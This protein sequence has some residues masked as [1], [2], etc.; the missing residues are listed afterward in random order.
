M[1]DVLVERFSLGMHHESRS[2]P[3]YVLTGSARISSL[4]SGIGPARRECTASTE[5]IT[6]APPAPPAAC[7]SELGSG[8]FR[9]G[10]TTMSQLARA[11]SHALNSTVVD[12]TQSPGTFAVDLAWTAG[13]RS[14]VVRTIAAAGFNLKATTEPVDVLVIDRASLPAESGKRALRSHS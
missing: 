3:T 6:T 8:Y 12:H 14:S 1:R 11:L 9:S 4:A 10:A 7:G 5:R 13:D 2:L